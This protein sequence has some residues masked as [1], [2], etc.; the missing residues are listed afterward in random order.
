M[1]PFRLLAFAATGVKYRKFLRDCRAPEAAY[2]HLWHKEIQPL[3]RGAT[4]WRRQGLPA[5]LADCPLT[6]YSTY[7]AALER[8]VQTG[9]S[10]L[11]DE[12]VLFFA[13][14]AGTSGPQKLFP[15]TRSFARQFQ[16]TTGPFVHSLLRSFDG[17]LRH[18]VLYFAAT[19]P[20]CFTPTGVPIGFISHFN[21]VTVPPLL[22]RQYCIPRAVLAD[23]ATFAHGAPLYALAQNLSGLLSVTPLSLSGLLGSLTGNWKEYLAILAG[24][25]PMPVNL[26]RPAIEPARLAMLRDL[27]PATFSF[28]QIWPGLACVACWTSS[29]CQ[30]QL[31]QIQSRLGVPVADAIYS[32]TEGWMNVPFGD[33]VREGGPLH[34]GAHIVEFLKEGDA[35]KPRNLI[36]PWELQPGSNYEVILTTAQGLVRYRLY[37][38]VA[39]TGMFAR[40]P[41]I[42][43]RY[44]SGRSISLGLAVVSESELVSA[45]LAAGFGLKAHWRFGPSAAGNGLSLYVPEDADVATNLLAAIDSEVRRMNVNYAQYTE[46]GTIAPLSIERLPASHPFWQRSAL[47]AQS[48]PQYL[49]Q[50]RP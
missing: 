18:P 26:P 34:P 38:V 47:H 28:K 40:S 13:Q 37:D 12:P 19:A 10:E 36:P 5:R 43:F 15:L 17:L 14:S 30:A 45:S 1:N 23:A 35:V 48:K 50:T 11:T 32:A 20:S 39:C 27:D 24:E 46:N 2:S 44:K 8:S 7:A 9:V 6:E 29:V 16:R 22:Q 21:Y 42:S 49:V 4:F 3:L 31:R 25:K 33:G 41:I